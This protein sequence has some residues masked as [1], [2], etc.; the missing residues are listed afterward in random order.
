MDPLEIPPDATVFSVAGR[1]VYLYLGPLEMR[2]LQREWGLTRQIADSPQDWQKKCQ[3]FQD[4][5]N[6]GNH[7]VMEEKLAVLRHALTRWG[8]ATGTDVS[9]DE[10]VVALLTN[11]DQPKKLKRRKAPF[12]YIADLYARFITEC[13]TDEEEPQQAAEEEAGDP[14]VQSGK[15]STR[16]G[17]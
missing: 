10:S 15:A 1:D 13:F 8:A 12:V 4:R 9:T 7:F 6:G 3:A 11:I 5:L 16:K 17:T 14:K 2:A